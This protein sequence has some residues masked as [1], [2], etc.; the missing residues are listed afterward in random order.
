MD[1][2]PSIQDKFEFR[3]SLRF[4][5]PLALR[6]ATDPSVRIHRSWGDAMAAAL[7]KTEAVTTLRALPALWLLIPDVLAPAARLTTFA[8][9]RAELAGVRP[10]DLRS[11]LLRGLLRDEASVEEAIAARDLAK[12]LN[13]S[14]HA[15]AWL[16]AVG[17]FPAKKTSPLVLALR[18][19][20]TEPETLSK[21]ILTTVD[22]FW[23]AG[24]ERTW[25]GAQDKLRR[26][27]ETSERFFRSC[28]L[29]EFVHRHVLRVVVNERAQELRATRSDDQIPFQRIRAAYVMPSMFNVLRSWTSCEDPEGGGTVIHLSCF[30]PGIGDL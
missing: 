10:D 17:L 7:P 24:F 8:E 3:V 14:R 25:Q 20:V 21:Q 28:S 22:A 18:R 26:S 23:K 29:A 27:M 15:N 16:T 6:V 2:D 4:E 19:L 5:L 12:V 13:G 1:Y 30:D 11:R 9:F